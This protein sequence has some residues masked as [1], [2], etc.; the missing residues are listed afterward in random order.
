MATITGLISSVC[1]MGTHVCSTAPASHVA[2]PSQK[3]ESST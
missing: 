3:P 2:S 1:Q